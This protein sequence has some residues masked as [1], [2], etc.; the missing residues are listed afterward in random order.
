MISALLLVVLAVEPPPKLKALSE[1][2][3]SARTATL[4]EANALS[5]RERYAE[6]AALVA[7]ADDELKPKLGEFSAKEVADSYLPT[8][9][10][11]DQKIVAAFRA[12]AELALTAKTQKESAKRLLFVL[13]DEKTYGVETA[14]VADPRVQ[15]LL[16]TLRKLDPTAK[17][18]FAPR[19]VKVV[20]DSPLKDTLRANYAQAVVEQLRLLGL[21]AST[22]VGD[23]EF[24][25]SASEGKVLD[26]SNLFGGTVQAMISCELIA[27]A[28][29]QGPNGKAEFETLDLKR[30][31]GGFSDIP[32]NCITSR[33]KDSATLAPLAVLRAWSAR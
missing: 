6:A 8:V 17:A 21:A 1:E 14:K 23:E 9:L 11:N 22:D 18:L 25:I 33:L 7:K 32:D 19:K 31:G 24:K 2:F 5:T 30:R 3:Q 12:R 15:E 13:L 20:I 26:A 16:A 28:R 27:S 4:K 29:W 10:D